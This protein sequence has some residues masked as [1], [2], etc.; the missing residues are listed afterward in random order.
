MPPENMIG[1]SLL[2]AGSKLCETFSTVSSLPFTREAFVLPAARF[3]TKTFFQKAIFRIED[4]QD[5][6]YNNENK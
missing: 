4:T 6:W 5:N 3:L 1:L 2:P